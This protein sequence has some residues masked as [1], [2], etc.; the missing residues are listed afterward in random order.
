M[1]EARLVVER[2]DE[3]GA[4]VIAEFLPERDLPL[5][6]K[7]AETPEREAVDLLA[8]E[9]VLHEH[10]ENGHRRAQRRGRVLLTAVVTL[11]IADLLH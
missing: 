10:L 3:L 1:P 8:V 2:R 9:G 6:W 11:H 7:T 5:D 4:L